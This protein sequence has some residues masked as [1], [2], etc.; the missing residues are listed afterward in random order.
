MSSETAA[1]VLLAEDDPVSRAYLAEILSA[2]GLSVAAVADGTHARAAARRELFELLVLDHRLPG[3]NGDRMLA[4][5]RADTSAAS[6]KTL[7]IATT[8]DPDP[9]THQLLCGAGFARVLIKPLGAAQ[10]HAVLHELGAVGAQSILD[11][12][13]GIAASGSVQA[14][15]QL[16]GLFAR[17]LDALSVELDVLSIDADALRERLH[18]LRASCGFCGAS[19][20][21]RAAVALHDALRSDN[22][23]LI[24]N[25]ASIFRSVL[26]STR[27]ALAGK[28]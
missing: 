15:D 13:T 7:A 24:G 8:A 3:I 21:D 5:L 4:S 28:D 25:A 27:A 20:L 12:G 16:R 9:R 10:L 6:N 23:A 2:L 18:R 26:M 22:R 19:A 17:E 11:D 1:R 14:L